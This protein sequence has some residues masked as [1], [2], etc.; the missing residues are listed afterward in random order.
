MNIPR[1]SGSILNELHHRLEA[2]PKALSRIAQYVLTNPEKVAKQSI[3]ELA[4]QS[5]SGQASVVRLVQSV[6]FDGFSEFKTALN[7][8]LARQ[9]LHAD[10]S[11]SDL[12][13]TSNALASMV[14]ADSA[15]TA[16][17][18][19][20]GPMD[21]VAKRLLASHRVWIFGSGIA[22]ICGEILEYRLLRLGLSASSVRD[23]ILMRELSD[24]LGNQ[25][26]AIAISDS[27]N[28][29]HTV[30]FLRDAAR[31]GA[32]TV[33]ISTRSR[34]PL[35]DEAKTL[36]QTGTTGGADKAGNVLGVVGRNTQVIETLGQCIERLTRHTQ[37]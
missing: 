7:V 23:P 11:F 17:L 37:E 14:A 12:E 27:G 15:E 34:S 10:Q 19:A 13:H 4:E 9:P 3:A 24:Q 5:R 28:T 30:A 31:R 35:A 33:A 32:Y 1:V 25:D 36:L 2:M 16:R 26:V 18:L 8:E 22:G 29:P 6:G 21:H 20:D